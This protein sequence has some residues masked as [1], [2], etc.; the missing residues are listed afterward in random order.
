MGSVVNGLAVGLAAHVVESQWDVVNSV[1]F[2]IR[3]TMPLKSHL[4]YFSP[5]TAITKSALIDH[6]RHFTAGV[7]FIHL[8]THLYSASTGIYY[9]IP[10]T[11]G[12]AGARDQT[13]D[14]LVDNPLP[15]YKFCNTMLQSKV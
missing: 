1:W 12:T 9:T 11:V 3:E 13:T 5:L 10:Y 8:H 4:F 7:T 2:S 6:S 14:L 15:T